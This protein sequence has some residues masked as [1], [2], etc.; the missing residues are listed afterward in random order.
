MSLGQYVVDGGITL[1]DPINYGYVVNDGAAGTTGRG[2][3]RL[4]SALPPS[5]P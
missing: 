5:G 2:R 4:R 1:I 3:F